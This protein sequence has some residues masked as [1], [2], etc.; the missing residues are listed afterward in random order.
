M[1]EA[2]QIVVA[3][4]STVAIAAL[5]KWGLFPDDGEGGGG[6][7][8]FT[9]TVYFGGTHYHGD[10]VEPIEG[11]EDAAGLTDIGR[12]VIQNRRQWIMG[13]VDNARGN[14]IVVVLDRNWGLDRQIGVCTYGDGRWRMAETQHIGVQDRC[15]H[16][17]ATVEPGQTHLRV[18][19]NRDD[20]FF[21]RPVDAAAALQALQRVEPRDDN[22][23]TS[24]DLLNGRLNLFDT[25]SG[26]DTNETVTLFELMATP[27][28][29]RVPAI[30]CP[31][32]NEIPS[33]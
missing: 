13:I 1:S 20:A 17:V 23:N 4:L 9:P 15:S 3:V 19:T 31:K 24:L 6:G 2:G 11:G 27:R 33:P 14:R 32:R 29:N 18:L 25:T 10:T 8:G 16:F 26:V 30:Y 12:M 5:T 7:G 21:N 28:A 22:D